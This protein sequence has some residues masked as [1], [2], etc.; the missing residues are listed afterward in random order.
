MEYGYTLEETTQVAVRMSLETLRK[1]QRALDGAISGE[2]TLPNYRLEDLRKMLVEVESHA[3]TSIA[4]EV[5][6][7]QKLLAAKSKS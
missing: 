6:A 2:N 3:L 7:R 5:E 4:Y 1:L